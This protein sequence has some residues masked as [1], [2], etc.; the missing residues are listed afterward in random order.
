LHPCTSSGR[1]PCL[2]F[3]QSFPVV[4]DN[5]MSDQPEEKPYPSVRKR[6]NLEREDQ[7]HKIAGLHF[8]GRSQKEIADQLGLSK[9]QICRDL[10]EINRRRKREIGNEDTHTL[11]AKEITRID[12]VEEMAS[13][14]Y[15]RS[16]MVEEI[17]S[18]E[19]TSP[20][21]GETVA[22]SQGKKARRVQEGRLK[23]SLRTKGR[24]GN[25]AFLKIMLECSKMRSSLQGLLDAPKKVEPS[26]GRKQIELIEV[27]KS[28]KSQDFLAPAMET[29]PIP[30]APLAPEP[31]IAFETEVPAPA[32]PS[33]P[34][35]A[36]PR[37]E[38]IGGME[39]MITVSER[40]EVKLQRALA[41]FAEECGRQE[42]K[43]TPP[44]NR[45]K[46]V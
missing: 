44:S 45:G 32:P 15:K 8:A 9:S 2:Q 1:T 22:G 7:L 16:S 38:W 18:Q 20:D 28:V 42:F 11:I 40:P 37:T 25:P 24:D 43:P 34:P 21:P 35:A 31:S 5:I 23:A 36:F 14:A 3:L 12:H 4:F 41:E 6:S 33:A 13:Q 26:D 30:S 29:V 27:V 17:Q 10:K 46:D 39:V 19:K